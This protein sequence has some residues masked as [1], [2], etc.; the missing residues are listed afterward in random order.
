MFIQKE[1]SVTVKGKGIHDITSI[2][3]EAIKKN[4]VSK[5]ICNLFIK[6]TSASLII[7]ENADPAVLEDLNNFYDKLVPENARY[8]HSQ[9]G[10]DDMPAHI[11]S[12][13]TN[14]DLNIPIKNGSLEL[15]T[16]QGV[17][18]F[19]HRRPINGSDIMRNFTITIMA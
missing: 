10:A 13:L 2:I 15:G 5:G 3:N 1:I 4:E 18:L 7:Q 6:H 8:I 17:Y 11:R 9:E 16:W 14:S 19:E 12:T